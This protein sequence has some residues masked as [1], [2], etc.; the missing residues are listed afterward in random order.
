MEVQ[1]TTMRKMMKQNI[2][3]WLRIQERKEGKKSTAWGSEMQVPLCL[4]V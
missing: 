1:G 4:Q 3:G 2:G